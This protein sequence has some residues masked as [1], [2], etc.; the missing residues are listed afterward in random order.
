MKSHIY[1]MEHVIFTIFILLLDVNGAFDIE[2]ML[3]CN[4]IFYD[5]I[6]LSIHLSVKL[7]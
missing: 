1:P 4:F 7:K 5:S 3:S 2:S 6:L